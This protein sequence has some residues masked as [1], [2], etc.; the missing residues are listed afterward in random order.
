[1]MPTVPYRK[2]SKLRRYE[3]GRKLRRYKRRWIIERTNA[4]STYSPSTEPSSIS[5]LDYTAEVFMNHALVKCW[6]DGMPVKCAASHLN[7]FA[8][9][10]NP[11]AIACAFVSKRKRVPIRMNDPTAQTRTVF[12]RLA[13]RSPVFMKL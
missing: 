4:M 6:R 7:R 11:F 2:N 9:V 13:P 1:M 5:P 12:M 3:D 8:T 10:C